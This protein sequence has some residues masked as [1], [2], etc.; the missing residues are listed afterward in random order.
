MSQL[1]ISDASS[2]PPK[3]PSPPH[4]PPA[5]EDDD[6]QPRKRARVDDGT[7]E[8]SSEIPPPAASNVPQA[9][10]VLFP[11]QPLN[12]FHGASATIKRPREIAHFSYD[13]VHGYREDESGINYYYR[14]PIGADLR[15]GFDTFQYYEDK[16]DPH[17]DSLLKTLVSKEKREDKKVQ[18]DFVTWRGMMTKIMTVPYDMFAEFEMLATLHDGTIYIHED[19]DAKA[20]SR[21]AENDPPRTNRRPDPNQQS[22]EMMTYWGYKFETLA[23]IPDVPQKVSPEFIENRTKAVVS[24]YAQHC[25]IV[26]TAFG[27]HGIVLGGE[28]DG[29]WHPKSSDPDAP[30]PWIELKTSEE[31]PPYPHNRD[32][33]KFERKLLKFWAQSFLLGV[34][35]VIVGF[36]SKQ[37]ILK[38]IDVYETVRI[39]G[40]VRR[41][42]GCWDG[43][44]CINF[45]AAFLTH[46][47]QTITGQGVYRVRLR[48]RGTHIEISKTAEQGTG[49]ILSK[50]FLDWRSED[51]EKETAGDVDN[52]AAEADPSS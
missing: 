40:M 42:T 30:I 49:K 38:V 21:A 36:R 39:P 41:G 14:P 10:P 4:P 2:L 34:E 37:G 52:P 17:L 1:P 5:T 50:E 23:L 46:L 51:K 11:I 7:R 26:R 3:P 8:L 27:P 32:I 12:R 25:S 28:V 24:N 45:A 20:A 48:K 33:L 47:K 9:Q 6:S 16:E 35:K 43:N 15:E 13:D 31:L 22:R 29:L 19:F 44:T 18:T